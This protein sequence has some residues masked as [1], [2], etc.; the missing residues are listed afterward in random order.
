MIEKILVQYLTSVLTVPVS[1]ERLNEPS[2]VLI[3]KTSGSETNF[4]KDSSVAIQSYGGSKLAAME[5]NEEVK[6]AMR[7]A[8]VR[9]EI[10]RVD[11]N[12]D[13]DYTDTTEKEYRYQ[14]VF[15]IT[16]Y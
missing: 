10:S 9:P 7:S 2:F 5:L 14:A 4:I 16:H 3:Q 8:C 11:L 6:E 13:Y 15:D 12:S 1:C